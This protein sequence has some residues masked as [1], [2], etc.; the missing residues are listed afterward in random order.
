MKI[1]SRLK[2]VSD[3]FTPQE[4]E[5]CYV[6]TPDEQIFYAKGM[7]SFYDKFLD[8][9]WGDCISS[10]EFYDETFEKAENFFEKVNK[11]TK[12]GKHL[13]LEQPKPLPFSHKA[14]DEKLYAPTVDTSLLDK[15]TKNFTQRLQSAKNMLDLF[16]SVE[17]GDTPE[18]TLKKLKKVFSKNKD[19]AKSYEFSEDWFWYEYERFYYKKDDTHDLKMRGPIDFYLIFRDGKLYKKYF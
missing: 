12:Q 8:L 18:E 5:D 13:L 6:L 2:T 17:I 10:K 9:L 14:N 19:L 1:L 7:D 4:L 11:A 16:F 3:Y 15:R